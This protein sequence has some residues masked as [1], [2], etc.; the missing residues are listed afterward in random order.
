MG[1]VFGWLARSILKETQKSGAKVPRIFASFLLVRC[2]SAS[3]YICEPTPRGQEFP[4]A[5]AGVI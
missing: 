4:P 1:S 5:V 2:C 3:G